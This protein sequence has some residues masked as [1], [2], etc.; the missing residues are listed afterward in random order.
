V[1]WSNAQDPKK[2]CVSAT[3][4]GEIAQGLRILADGKRRSGLRARYERSVGLAFDRRIPACD[5]S[6]ARIDGELMGDRKEPGLPM[7]V[8]DGQIAAVARP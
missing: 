4:I 7:S 2:R 8:S 1:A 3:T 5:E 6:A